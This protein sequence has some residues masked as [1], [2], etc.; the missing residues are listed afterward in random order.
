[1]GA[2]NQ[3]ERIRKGWIVGFVD[4]EGT[5]SITVQRNKE[6]SLGWQVFPEFVVTQGEKNLKVLED[7]KLYFGCGSVYRNHRYD[8]HKEDIYR[9]C[10]RSIIDLKEKI[11]PFFQKHPLKTS[12]AEDFKK[13]VTVIDAIKEK[14][15]LTVSGLKRIAEI[16][17]TMN[18]RQRTKL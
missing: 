9:Y 2:D 14:K 1:M 7:M 5:F 4:G 17:Q 8:N 13:F 11:I 10:V 12:K 3:Q 16:A 6:M 18:N 15:H